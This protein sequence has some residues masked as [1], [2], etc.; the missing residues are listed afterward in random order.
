MSENK[1]TIMHDQTVDFNCLC[2]ART[3]VAPLWPKLANDLIRP[4]KAAAVEVT[5]TLHRL[6][7]KLIDIIRCICNGLFTS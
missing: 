4:T 1:E 7:R 6:A 5:S 2:N 3:S